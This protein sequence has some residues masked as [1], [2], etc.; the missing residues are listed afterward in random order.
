[1]QSMLMYYLQSNNREIGD[2]D[3]H[4]DVED[5]ICGNSHANVEDFDGVLKSV[6]YA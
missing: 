3:V 6:F 1:M 5:E 2:D 4:T